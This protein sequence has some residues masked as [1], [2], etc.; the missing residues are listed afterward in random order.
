MKILLLFFSIFTFIDCEKKSKNSKMRHMEDYE[1]IDVLS[2]AYELTYKKNSVLKAIIKTINDLEKEAKFT[3]FLRSEKGQ[4]QYKLKCHN[5][6]ASTI[7]CYSDKVKFDLDDKYYFY[8]DRG[9]D[10]IY[11][12]D[13]SDTYEDFKRVSLIFKPEIY[14]NQ[15]MYKDHKKILGLNNRKVMGGG[16]LYLVRKSKKILHK[17]K[18]GFN[19]YIN[20]NNFISHAGLYG[21]MPQS[22]LIAYKEAIR[23]GF[24]I[25]DASIQFTKDKIPVICNEM[26]LEKVSDGFG[27]IRAKTLENLKDLDFG[28]K[29]DKKY[30]GEKILTFEDL[31]IL[32]KEDNIIIDLDLSKLGFQKY[33]EE[34]DKYMKIIMDIIDKFDMFDSVIFDDG[35]EPKKILKLKEIRKE[36]YVSISNMEENGKID[37]K[38]KGFKEIINNIGDLSKDIDIDKQTV[39]SAL[40]LGKIIKVGT[41]NNLDIANK[42]QEWGVNL[43]KTNK[44]HPFLINNEKEEPILIKCTQFDVLADCR[45]DS[46]VK[47]IDNEIY[48][49]YYSENIY[50][51][52]EDIN[53]IPIGEFKYLDTK[54]LDDLFYT[55]KEFDFEKGFLRLNT[56]VDIRKGTNLTGFV[57]PAGYEHN[58][59]ECYQ[60]NFTCEGNNKDEV[61]CEIFK[62]DESKVKYKGNYS[63]YSIINYSLYVKPEEVKQNSLF[64]INFKG[65][66]GE[67][68]ISYI[69]CI[70]FFTLVLILLLYKLK[71]KKQKNFFEDLKL[72]EI[73]YLKTTL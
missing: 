46:K 38:Y 3:A 65:P 26:D 61:Y 27:T 53:E 4:K 29:F 55:V 25:V 52:N 42:I 43:I 13:E 9:D 16:Y 56:S 31:L 45:L 62:K 51:K 47:L 14:E 8:Y 57:G 73:S 72:E 2:V 24:H 33:F 39:K 19:N 69:V 7:D 5:T 54:K 21:Q 41:I 71:G 23:R 67:V 66:D 22:T 48:S 63:V 18:D 59:P 40:S 34:T 49:I 60:Y 10:G 36:I 11:T 37:K 15:I 68:N 35:G 28:S 30:K 17:S 1:N 6:S 20:L 12:F 50:K 70:I 64:N 58:A 32:C 44:L